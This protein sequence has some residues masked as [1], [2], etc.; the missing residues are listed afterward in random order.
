MDAPQKVAWCVHRWE[1][2]CLVYVMACL[3]HNTAL[4]GLLALVAGGG[5]GLMTALCYREHGTVNLS[6]QQYRSC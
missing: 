5:H 3:Q 4:E 1:I 6:S 2:R